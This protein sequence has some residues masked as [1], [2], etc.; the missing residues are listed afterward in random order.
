MHRGRR[1]VRDD[2]TARAPDIDA[3]PPRDFPLFSAACA[4]PRRSPF[5]EATSGVLRA[6]ASYKCHAR[7]QHENRAEED[8]A[9]DCRAPPQAA[10]GRRLRQPVAEGGAERTR[11]HVGD[12][13][14]GDRAEPEPVMRDGN[15]RDRG[16]ECQRGRQISELERFR[17]EI[18]RGG[19]EREGEQ[20]REPIP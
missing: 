10:I 20:N 13:E 12:P 5:L 15:Q 2:G 8:Q 19:T 14:R 11:E 4:V 18:T 3:G 6:G 16:R 7:H 1:P 17:R 9:G